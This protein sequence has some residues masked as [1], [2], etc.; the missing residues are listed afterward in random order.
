MTPSN[1]PSVTTTLR[2]DR[3]LRFIV[4]GA[5]L[6]G[7]MSVVKLQQ[8]GFTDITVY[9]KADRLGGTWRDNTYPGIACDI[10]SHFYSY[11]FAPNPDWS[12]RYSPGSEIQSYVENVARSHGVDK[13]IR[14]SEEIARCEFS[15]GRWQ[16]TTKD[17]QR[18]SADVVIAATGVLHQPSIPDLPG[19]K[20]FA[21]AAFHSARW[22]HQTAIDGE[23]I[24]VIG[25]GS[26]SVQI[27]SAL[28]DRVAKLSLF[29]RT[30]Q[31]IMPQ[32]NPAFSD[33]DKAKFRA[34]PQVMQ[35]IRK[36][37]ARRF[38]ANFSD[39]VI[40]A[41]S[42]QLHVIENTCRDYLESQVSDVTLRE[43]LRPKHRAACKRL[44]ISPD[45][46]QAIQK[47]NAELV[48]DGIA[49]V[50]PQGVRTRNGRLHELDV[51]ILATG[52]KADSFVRP[53][54]VIGRNGHSLDEQW[55]Q[56]PSAYMCVTVP[57]MP[58]FFMLNGPSSPVGNYP[59]IEVAELQMGYALQLIELLRTQ[60]CREIA[61]S[62]SATVAFNAERVAA[63]KNT[64]WVTGCN[65]WYMDDQ[66]VPSAWPFSIDRFYTELS[67]PNIEAYEL[68]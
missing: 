20:A 59:L 57:N 38:R 23:R 9:E 68:R 44:V 46:Y 29:Q 40:D 34:N 30:A 64:I 56:R 10:P 62:E 51:L 11:S 54:Q 65:S 55:S 66:G 18:D 63:T 19:L 58:N 12:R 35:H 36:E 8:A 49:C 26:S 53:V 33:D 50:E 3:P 48:T 41:N 28:V 21:G 37:T 2:A 4:I 27:V 16:L 42:P 45:F 24:G 15:D 31:W 39:A 52:F 67:A 60:R 17:G 6:S 47:P 32:E 61:P 5:G 43:Q 13:V 7:V 14:Y 25:N 22:N 1:T